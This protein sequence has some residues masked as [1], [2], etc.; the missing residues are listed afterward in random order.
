MQKLKLKIKLK[1]YLFFNL[2]V[3]FKIIFKTNLNYSKIVLEMKF[4]NKL[5]NSIIK[6]S[7]IQ[8]KSMKKKFYKKFNKMI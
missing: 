4:K 2:I 8:I 5:K 3:A 6:F 7:K 1:I